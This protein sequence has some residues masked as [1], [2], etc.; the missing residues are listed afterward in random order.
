MFIS[1]WMSVH[2]NGD[3]GGSQQYLSKGHRWLLQGQEAGSEATN[4]K[5]ATGWMRSSRT[6][7]E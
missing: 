7:A 5:E 4:A 2:K 1:I 6:A 3:R